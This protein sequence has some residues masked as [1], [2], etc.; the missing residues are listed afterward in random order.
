MWLLYYYFSN[1]QIFTLYVS[2]EI[3][4][5]N[6]ITFPL[7]LHWQN[8]QGR[9]TATNLHERDS[10]LAVWRDQIL[11][12]TF[13]NFKYIFSL[14]TYLL[15]YY[16]SWKEYF[17]SISLCT[18]FVWEAINKI[19]KAWSLSTTFSL[20][21]KSFKD[22]SLQSNGEPLSNFGKKCDMQRLVLLNAPSFRVTVPLGKVAGRQ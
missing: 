17:L 4:S 1:S 18:W 19:L 21:I 14:I 9:H 10:K 20:V 2:M 3:C 22:H 16:S 12:H 5:N 15:S 7:C 6:W 11:F 8:P 13:Y